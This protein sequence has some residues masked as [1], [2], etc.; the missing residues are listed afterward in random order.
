[1]NIEKI[2]NNGA[3]RIFFKN[4]TFHGDKSYEVTYSQELKSY[5]LTVDTELTGKV[6]YLVSDK[7]VIGQKT[8]L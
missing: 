4:A 1:M 7:G 8:N 5:I 6:H 2:R 3:N